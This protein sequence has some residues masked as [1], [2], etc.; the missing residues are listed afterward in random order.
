MSGAAHRSVAHLSL[1]AAAVLAWTL[2][3]FPPETSRFYPQCPVFFWLHLYCPGC[4]ATRALA[5][6]LHGRLSDAL[7]WNALAVAFIP[8]AVAFFGLSY[9]RAVRGKNFHWPAIPSRALVLCF[10]AAA[11]FTV[12][13]NL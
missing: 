4:G 9:L 12:L 6:L 11:V 10:A 2:W 1:L 7:R 3:R 13:R 5:A 8:M